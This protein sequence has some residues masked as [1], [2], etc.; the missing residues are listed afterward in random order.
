M[1]T[2]T[3]DLR[4]LKCPMPSLLARRALA[5]AVAGATVEVVCDDPL[6]PIDV[7]HMCRENGYDVLT[8]ERDGI[9]TRLI[10]RRPA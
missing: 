8:V 7:P 6:A 3:L 1:Q 10:L 2:T 9:V 5:R 4:G